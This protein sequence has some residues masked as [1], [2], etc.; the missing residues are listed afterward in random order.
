MEVGPPL[1]GAWL[2]SYSLGYLIWVYLDKPLKS[3]LGEK[4]PSSPFGEERNRF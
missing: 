2:P 1:P 3:L 4:V